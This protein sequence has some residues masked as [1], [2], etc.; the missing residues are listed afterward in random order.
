MTFPW[1]SSLFLL[2]AIASAQSS[3]LFTK[4]PPDVD[5]ALR[6][7]IATFYQAHVSGKYHEAL[8]VVAEDAL[9]DFMAAGKDQYKSCEIARINYLENFTRAEATVACKGELHW[10]AQH[11]P[12]TMPLSSSWKLV[13]GQWS[14][15][16]LKREAVQTPWGLSRSDPKAGEN[17]QMPV[18]PPDPM[19]LAR[20]IL[21]KVT[22][23][24]TDLTLKGYEN[25]VDEVHI[26]NGMPGSIRVTVTFPSALGLT[27]KPDKLELKGGERATIV[28]AFSADDVKALCEACFKPVKPSV[29]ANIQ[30]EPTNQSFPVKITFAIPPELQK[31]LPQQPGKH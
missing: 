2:C 31:L 13:N 22:L 28:F 6:A 16:L 8:K 19:A 18:I 7:R 12:A 1:I 15:Y 21:Q 5:E 24:K 11:M 20:D 30:I 9:D 14:W 17:S 25:S 27:V 3:D 4:A 10:R 23:D 29:T 26:V